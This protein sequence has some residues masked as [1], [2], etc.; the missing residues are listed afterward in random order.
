MKK[1]I[2]ID[3][4]KWSMYFIGIQILTIAVAFL[5]ESGYGA[6]PFDNGFIS[7]A[8]Y[9]GVPIALWMN[10]FGMIMLIVTGL[11]LRKIPNFFTYITTFIIAGSL[12]FWVVV[13]NGKI[14]G[15]VVTF[16]I[17]M[18]LHS[19]GIALYLSSQGMPT[20]VDYF[21]VNICEI[22]KIKLMWIRMALDGFGVILSLLTG[23]V[24]GLGTL[25]LFICMGPMIQF[26]MKYIIY[27]K[28]RIERI[29][30]NKKD[31]K[32]YE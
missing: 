30:D 16:I 26:F 11:M 23:G 12:N 18:I 27:T 17:G 15:G 31:L 21:M 28:L 6:T 10:I 19:F 3:Y 29:I 32:L 2:K 14:A 20:A 25:V 9:T 5:N 13:L 4:V 8:N 1:G 7:L 22:K 24:V